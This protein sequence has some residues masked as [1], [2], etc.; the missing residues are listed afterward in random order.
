MP[1]EDKKIL[2]RQR[3]ADGICTKCGKN[4][5]RQNRKTC[6]DCAD[7]EALCR[8]KDKDASRKQKVAI[9]R[10]KNGICTTCGTN[11]KKKSSNLCESCSKKA[12][13]SNRRLRESRKSDKICIRCG[14][15]P[16]YARYKICQECRK[17][18]AKTKRQ[19]YIDKG[20]CKN[21]GAHPI[22]SETTTTCQKCFDRAK[23]NKKKRQSKNW[24]MILDHYG[25]K[26]NCCG[27]TTT[28]F[29]TLDHINNDGAVHKRSL[30]TK[31]SHAIKKWV[32]QNHFPDNF[33]ILCYNCNCVRNTLGYCPH[34]KL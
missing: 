18:E 21:C 26:C 4:D 20:L 27:E 10:K 24:E 34:E 17:K 28:E 16:T 33:Q 31:D 22:R 29:L 9:F 32:V 1:R 6:Q 2:Y 25:P 30:N 14:G 8:N 3:V 23:A 19:K 12:S 15:R 11:K 13:Q 7:Y 5:S